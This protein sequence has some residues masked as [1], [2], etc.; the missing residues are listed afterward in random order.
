[1]AAIRLPLRPAYNSP[2]V[3]TFALAACLVMIGNNMTRGYLTPSF[4]AVYPGFEL[5]NPL[6]YFRLV[7]HVLGHKNWSHLVA[8]FSVILLV[9]PALEEKYGSSRLIK[10]MLITALATGLLNAIFFSTGLLGAS[11]L[12]FMMI[13]L[14]SFTNHK[15]GELP[16][17]FVL[18]VVLYL[19][20]EVVQAFSQDDISQF[21]HIMGGICGSLFGF[22]RGGRG[23]K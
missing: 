7:S 12:A 17:T 2:V 21:A 18:V 5:R 16:L 9:G 20:K 19:A 8:N 10:M 3:L 11:G 15:D 13:L 14:S 4:F 23:G 22:I 1:M 6:F